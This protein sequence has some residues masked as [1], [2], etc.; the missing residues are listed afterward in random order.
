MWLGWNGFDKLLVENCESCISFH[1]ILCEQVIPFFA[2]FD[3]VKSLEIFEEQY[4]L[5]QGE[6]KK[7]ETNQKTPSSSFTYNYS[8]YVLIFS[9]HSNLTKKPSLGDDLQ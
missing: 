1:G 6:T 2:H 3:L 4:L 7:K 5:N 8:M 9:L